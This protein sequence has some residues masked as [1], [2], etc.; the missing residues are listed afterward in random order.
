MSSPFVEYDGSLYF[1]MF[2]LGRGG[3]LY[4]TDGTPE[5]SRRLATLG[6]WPGSREFVELNGSLYFASD[7]SL[8]KMTTCA[9]CGL[10]PKGDS[11]SALP[12]MPSWTAFLTLVMTLVATILAVDLIK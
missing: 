5:G 3:G 12:F 7:E 10:L 6:W 9:D 11:S 1:A 8:Y 2:S 4:T